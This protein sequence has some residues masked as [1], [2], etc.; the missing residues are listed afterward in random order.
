MSF[1]AQWRHWVAVAVRR[2]EESF[3][4]NASSSGDQFEKSSATDRIEKL[5]LLSSEIDE[6]RVHDEENLPP[7]SL[8]LPTLRRSI[9]ITEGDEKLAS[10][11]S[12][13]RA[14]ESH[15]IRVNPRNA[16]VARRQWALRRRR[17][18]EGP[19]RQNMR[20]VAAP[21]PTKTAQ[22]LGVG[23]PVDPKRAAGKKIL[24]V[25]RSR[26]E[27]SDL[28]DPPPLVS[29]L[30]PLAYERDQ[31]C[32]LAAA[33]G[34]AAA[35]FDSEN[36]AALGRVDGILQVLVFLAK[37]ESQEVVSLACDVRSDI[38]FYKQ[39]PRRRQRI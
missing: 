32:V 13:T 11:V 26:G 23:T 33:K 17:A 34:I 20:I 10:Q 4:R 15:R 30:L 14:P 16:S 27:N 8:D 36:A 35:S 3:R 28:R 24:C 12:L 19:N 31:E 37:H 22:W 21:V 39:P 29:T 38:R 6:K 5:T 2:E 9:S 7:T 1:R 18:C 25:K